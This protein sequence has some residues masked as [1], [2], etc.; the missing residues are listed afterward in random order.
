MQLL[1]LPLLHCSVFTFLDQVHPKPS[2]VQGFVS[3]RLLLVEM[4]T[5][6]IHHILPLLLELNAA[7]I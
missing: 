2:F 6:N 4:S 5:Q 7:P 1:D 3:P